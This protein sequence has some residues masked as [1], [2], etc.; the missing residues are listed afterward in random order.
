MAKAGKKANHPWV[1]AATICEEVLEEKDNVFS[2]IRMV[3]LFNVPKPPE[4]DGKSNLQ[5]FLKG[6]VAFRSGGVRGTRAVKVYGV[7]PKGK[8][9]K[10]LDVAVEF[11][12]GNTGVNIRLNVLFG[13]KS[14]GTHWL[15][16]YVEKWLASRIPLTIVFQSPKIPE[17]ESKTKEDQS[18]P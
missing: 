13:F 8:R 12:G 16:V 10:L 6:V 7:S 18:G 15:D 3:D 14:E 11:L 9:R 4:W 2:I 17:S 1:A 5:L